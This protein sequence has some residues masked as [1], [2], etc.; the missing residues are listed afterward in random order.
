MP[1]PE[2]LTTTKR[3]APHD[4][5]KTR[6]VTIFKSDSYI[7]SDSCH[8]YIMLD[9]TQHHYG[10]ISINDSYEDG[11]LSRINILADERSRFVSA[12]FTACDLSVPKNVDDDLILHQ[13]LALFG[14]LE[15]NPYAEIRMFLK[16][17]NIVFTGEYWQP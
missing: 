13:C 15:R 6:S 10:D 16:E 9:Y 11:S 3:H 5:K 14:H 7:A 8:M 12:I 17:N 1:V 4:V 2:L